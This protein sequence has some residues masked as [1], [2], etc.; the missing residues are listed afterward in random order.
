MINVIIIDD[1]KVLLEGLQQLINKSNIARVVNVGYSVADCKN[2]LELD[3]LP[4]VLMLD[5]GLPDG[6]GCELCA[7]L[8]KKYPSLKII[9]LTTYAEVTVITRA[10][11]S[12]ALGYVLK[13]ASFDEICEGI[14]TVTMGEHFLCNDVDLTLKKT[15]E[16][17]ITLTGR[18]RELLKLIVQGKTNVEIA[19]TLCLAYQTV[20]GYRSNLMLKLQVHNAAELVKTTIELKLV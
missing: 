10:L 15:K 8:V 19:D 17:R 13:N 6:D 1:H 20:K 11:E 4:D 7:E 16:R 3:G 12:G 9:M 14:R 18:E 5:V 2:L